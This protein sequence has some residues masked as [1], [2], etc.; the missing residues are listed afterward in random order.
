[1]G[2]KW[3]VDDYFLEV[4]KDVDILKDEEGWV[5]TLPD[6]PLVPGGKKYRMLKKD[7]TCVELWRKSAPLKDATSIEDIKKFDWDLFKIRDEVLNGIK[8]RAEYLYNKTDYGLVLFDVGSLHANIGQVL[9]GWT[10]WL[11]DLKIRRPLAEAIL[12]RAMEVLNYNLHKY[13]DTLKDY[14]QV[15]GFADDLG[16]QEGPQISPQLFKDVYKHR[17]E[18]LFGYVKKHS[19]MFVLLHSDGAISP[20]LKDLLIDAGLDAINPVQSTCKGMN[21][22]RLK[23]DFGEQLTFWGGGADTQGILP[24]AKPEK[25]AKHVEKLV[26]IF[27]PGGGYVYATV[28]IIPGNTPPE[29]IVSAFKAAYESGKY[30]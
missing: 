8:K 2:K 12:D 11:V 29:N 17:Y 28:H 1:L 14:I 20:L 9:R 13:V 4:Q 22:E 24:Y 5:L 16:T 6:N 27:S 7:F 19:K 30:H 26:S 23:K 10:Q 15:I 3:N 25:V 21:P 18:E